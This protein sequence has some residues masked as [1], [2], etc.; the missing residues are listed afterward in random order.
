MATPHHQSPKLPYPRQLTRTESLDSLSHWVSCVRNYFRRTPQFQPFFKRS[1]TWD[2]TKQNYGFETANAEDEADNLEALLDTIS[3]FLPGPYITNQITK[4]TTNIQS[5]WD[6]IWDHYGVK[7]SQSSFF[8]YMNI[9]RTA[10]ERYIDL[11]D[12]MIYHTQNHLCKEGTDGGP[13][14][15]G[16]LKKDDTITLSHRNS[17]ALDWLKRIDPRLPSI[18]R[19]EYSKDLKSG[20]PLAALVKE[21]AENVDS[22]LQ[23]YSN[24]HT[25]VNNITTDQDTATQPQVFRVFNRPNQQFGPR[26]N[27]FR[28]RGQFSAQP[29]TPR[30]T[31]RF[32]SSPSSS[33]KQFFCQNCFSLGRRLSIKVD[34]NHLPQ[35]CPQLMTT[36]RSVQA[37]DDLGNPLHEE[38]LQDLATDTGNNNPDIVPWA[39]DTVN[40]IM[41]IEQRMKKGTLLKSKSPSVTAKFGNSN[42]N[43][44]IDEG[45]EICCI[46]HQFALNNDIS[47]SRTTESAV[48][49]GSSRMQLMGETDENI[50][51]SIIPS[52]HEIR[53]SLGKC[54][55]VLNLGCPILIGEPGKS[56]NNILTDP[57]S[58]QITTIN[59]HGKKIS[60]PYTKPGPINSSFICRVQESTVVYPDNELIVPV[61]SHYQEAQHLFFAPRREALQSSPP[62]QQCQV[63]NGEVRIVNSSHSPILLKKN[64]HFGDLTSNFMPQ[65]ND[66]PQSSDLPSMTKNTTFSTKS[67]HLSDTKI[68]P[69]N[70]MPA[71]WKTHFAT[72]LDQY[73]DIITPDPGVY[74]GFYG[75]IDCS[76]NFIK[77]PPASNKARLPSYSHDKLSKMADIMDDMERMG[78]LCKPEDLGIIPRNVHT[79]Y[80]IPKSDNSYRFVTDFTSLLPFIGKL[81]VC[82]PTIAQA[83]QTLSSFRYHIELDLSHC[84]WQGSISPEDSKYLATPHPFG[85]IRV[86]CREPQGIRNA[87]EHNSERLARIF[88][89]LEQQKK[90][91]RL[92]DG[93]YVGGETFEELSDNFSIVMNRA[94]L[95]NLTFKPSKIIICPKTTILFGWKKSGNFWS[96][97]THVTTPLSQAP[98][99]KTVKQLRGY[100]GAY[101]Q[102]SKTIPNYSIH[103]QKLEKYAG[104]KNSRDHIKWSE[105]LV[106]EFNSA[107]NSL[108]DIHSIA[109]PSPSD[110]LHIYTDFS[111]SANAVG[112]HLL[113]QRDKDDKKFT[114]G[115]YYSTRLEDCQTRWTPCEKECLGIKLGIEH[116]KPYILESKNRTIIH[117]DNLICVQ[118]WNRLK[119]GLISTSSK[120]AAF[121]ACLCENNVEIVHYPGKL[122]KVADFASR[123]PV[124]CTEKNCQTCN[125]AFEQVQL[126]DSTQLRSVTVADLESG[127]Y[128]IPLSEKPTWLK[129]QKEDDTHRRLFNLITS[130]GLQPEPKLRGHS[131][132]KHM[133]NMYKKGNLS[134]DSYGLIIVKHIDTNSG[135][136]YDAISVPKPFY[137]S[138]LQSL[139]IKLDHP[140]KNQLLKFANRHFF[141]FGSTNSI[142]SVHNSCEICSR[143]AILP[144]HVDEF[145]TSA[146]PVFGKHFSADVMVSDNQKIFI[147]RENLTQYTFSKFIENETSESLEEA[148]V[149]AVIDIMPITG[150]T[151][152]VDPSPAFQSLAQSTQ[153]SILSRHNITLDIG[154]VHNKNKNPIAEN[155][156]KEFRKEKVRLKKSGGP[157]TELDRI[158][159]TKNMNQRIRN[160]GLSSKEMCYRRDVS[161]NELIEI[162][163]SYLCENQLNKKKK[164]NQN[165]AHKIDKTPQEFSF[166]IGDRVL[167]KNDLNKYRGR[168]EYFISDFKS[169]AGE[170][171]AILRKSEK[172]FRDKTYDLKL[173]E[174][175]PLNSGFKY[176]DIDEEKEFYGFQSTEI[177]QDDGKLKKIIKNLNVDNNID[178][179]DDCDSESF[180]GFYSNDVPVP[181]NELANVIKDMSALD[182]QEPLISP[183]NIFNVLPE[184]Q[185]HNKSRNGIM[186]IPPLHGWDENEWFDL[187]DEFDSDCIHYDHFYFDEDQYEEENIFFQESMSSQNIDDKSVIQSISSNDLS[188]IIPEW[189][190]SIKDSAAR[191]IQHFWKGYLNRKTIIEQKK[192]RKRS[193]TNPFFLVKIPVISDSSSELSDDGSDDDTFLSPA[194]SSTPVQLYPFDNIETG[195][196]YDVSDALSH[197]NIPTDLSKVQDVS[198][199]LELL[200]TTPRRSTRNIDRPDYKLLHES[201]VRE[202]KKE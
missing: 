121:L 16:L 136:Q 78:V 134:I 31:N 170:T 13:H 153:D 127:L 62:P 56:A 142:D 14:A 22:L 201:G 97:T 145:S 30:F 81:E 10:D 150:C 195:R 75:D 124:P 138:L 70:I 151:V 122:T 7:P 117:T 169:S 180:H 95:C 66:L 1:A 18:V 17:I 149:E 190:L 67:S 118:A 58:K 125:Y 174:I 37:P 103:L 86:Y 177:Q 112:A 41:L 72:I 36:V 5:V 12:K 191:K 2:C 139:H 11:Y 8:D 194:Q 52:K 147:C 102:L 100:I 200:N 9:A 40:K 107:K 65:S 181:N 87:S 96:P 26:N 60:I 15:G 131:D 176:H 50:I 188:L 79:S 21:I 44:I 113:I 178:S 143:V 202:P 28:G 45:S 82:S 94:K 126:G 115:G 155:C 116:F 185:E 137:V 173:S 133:Y 156:I 146:N 193:S 91:C 179:S 197:L 171:W 69:D 84:Y 196:V 6:I 161:S 128:K 77:D 32:S 3:S 68:D 192:M 33:S 114:N 110:I 99:P 152:R 89:D 53:W 132:L 182:N 109:I 55:V 120:V 39:I 159:I 63:T 199:A 61:P 38:E 85:G 19:T 166:K 74:N 184:H 167:I 34:S 189:D 57:V 111:E 90:M 93:L 25:S 29:S 130:G 47:F 163:D 92:A 88:G 59:V 164:A 148:I 141:C 51:L 129:L 80:L 23:R 175:L 154:R 46:D 108:K 165:H 183:S 24:Q 105:E 4:T 158:I 135:L 73:E 83:K 106:A 168:E 198:Q 27:N 186:N 71:A 119:Q 104:G 20:T 187:L 123:N 98:L 101:R 48:S 35:Q 43:C 172:K 157:I 76:L 42:T 140:S 144:K 49:A 160:R 54:I 64:L 162:E